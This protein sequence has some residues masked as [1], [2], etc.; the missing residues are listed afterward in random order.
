MDPGNGKYENVGR[1]VDSL[2]ADTAAL[3]DHLQGRANDAIETLL[4]RIE[5][6]AGRIWD[7]VSRQSTTSVEVVERNIEDK[8]WISLMFAFLA[9]AAI[10]EMFRWRR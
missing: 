2:R 10:S 3:A 6:T 8:P 7:V 9:G 5:R 1:E 4:H